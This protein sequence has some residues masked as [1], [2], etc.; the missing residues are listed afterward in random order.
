[1]SK[2]GK[3]P[4]TCRIPV[5]SSR[6]RSCW[7]VFAFVR[8]RSRSCSSSSGFAFSGGGVLVHGGR[9]PHSSFT[10]EEGGGLCT[11]N[12]VMGAV[13][14]QGGDVASWRVGPAS[15]RSPVLGGQGGGELAGD[16]ALLTWALS[17]SSSPPASCC[18]RW[19][20]VLRRFHGVCGRSFVSTW[21]PCAFRLPV[22][23]HAVV[24]VLVGFAVHS[25]WS[26]PTSLDEG[27]GERWGV[28]ARLALDVAKSEVVGIYA[29]RGGLGMPAAVSGVMS[30]HGGWVTYLGPLL[31]FVNPPVSSSALVVVCGVR[32]VTWRSW[33]SPFSS[34]SL[35]VRLGRFRGVRR[36]FVS[37]AFRGGWSANTG[38]EDGGGNIPGVPVTFPALVVGRDVREG[39][40]GPVVVVV[41]R[42]EQTWQQLH[43]VSEFGRCRPADP[44]GGIY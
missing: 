9:S 44:E 38:G 16:G 20:L 43:A 33:R 42:K 32:G 4:P 31:P 25:R 8:V 37:C 5:V 21:R 23:V 39:G 27:R 24:L 11:W 28:V 34:S 18:T 30:W 40:R 29:D 22:D 6:S 26:S 13:R 10:L 41:G 2:R 7:P 35:G 12:P 3:T 17:F 15:A 1:L 36:V 19:T 14:Y